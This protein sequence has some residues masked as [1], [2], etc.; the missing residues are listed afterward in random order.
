MLSFAGDTFFTLDSTYLVILTLLEGFIF[1]VN[2]D[3]INYD[4]DYKYYVHR[5]PKVVFYILP[6]VFN[7]LAIVTIVFV[8]SNY[9]WLLSIGLIFANTFH[10]LYAKSKYFLGLL[11]VV[12]FPNFLLVYFEVSFIYWYVVYILFFTVVPYFILRRRVKVYADNDFES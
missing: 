11:C 5:L 6:I 10:L 7:V 4:H 1:K 3:Y 8:S 12:L 9:K 2:F